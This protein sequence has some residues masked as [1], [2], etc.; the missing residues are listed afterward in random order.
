MPAYRSTEAT[1]IEA[2][3]SFER[4]D[5]EREMKNGA[6]LECH[7]RVSTG[8]LRL[9]SPALDDG[10]PER[11][12]GEAVVKRPVQHCEL[13]KRLRHIL[14]RRSGLVQP[15]RIDVFILTRF[16]VGSPRQ[17]GPASDPA[18]ERSDPR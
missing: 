16:Q 18:T 5:G 1:L 6:L 14:R 12:C 17:G 15:K 9:W 7:D 4:A 13:P 8:A 11:K 3:R 2:K 10:R